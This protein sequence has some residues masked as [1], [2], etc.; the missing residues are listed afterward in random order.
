MDLRKLLADS[1]FYL[2]HNLNGFILTDSSTSRIAK[3][4]SGTLSDLVPFNIEMREGIFLKFGS[5]IDYYTVEGMDDV[6]WNS[7][8]LD[9]YAFVDWIEDGITGISTKE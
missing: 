5:G 4:Q 6:N 2:Y 1:G 8:H 3:H 9:L 7:R